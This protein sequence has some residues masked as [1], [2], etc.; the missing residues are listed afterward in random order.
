VI[1]LPTI[2]KKLNLHYTLSL[3]LFGSGNL[4]QRRQRLQRRHQGPLQGS[5]AR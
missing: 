1:D 3:D 2:Q 5:Q 4:D